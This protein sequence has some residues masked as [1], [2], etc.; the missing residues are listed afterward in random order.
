MKRFRHQPGWR[1]R[2]HYWFAD[3][4]D[5]LGTLFAEELFK[6]L[7]NGLPESPVPH[8]LLVVAGLGIFLGCVGKMA[9]FPLHVWLPDAMEGPTPVSALIHAATMVAAGLYLVGVYPLFTLE[10]RL[11][12]AYT[13]DRLIHGRNDRHRDDRRQSSPPIQRLAS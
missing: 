8:W 10:A 2:V 13:G 1:R 4:V 7:P 6:L 3:P 5:L 9:E 11:V 12:I